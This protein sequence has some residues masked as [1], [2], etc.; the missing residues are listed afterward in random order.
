MSGK[1]NYFVIVLLVET[2]NEL[3]YYCHIYLNV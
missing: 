2:Q 3:I 1:W